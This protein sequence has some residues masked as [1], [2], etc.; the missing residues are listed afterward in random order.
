MLRSR[1]VENPSGGHSRGRV[2]AILGMASTTRGLNCGILCSVV[3]AAFSPNFFYGMF[4]TMVL[5]SITSELDFPSASVSG[6]STALLL[7][8]LARPGF[9]WVQRILTDPHSTG[10]QL[11]SPLG[12]KNLRLYRRTSLFVLRGNDLRNNSQLTE[13]RNSTLEGLLRGAAG[14]PKPSQPNPVS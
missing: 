5:A 7:L 6:F 8:K 2:A 14:S 13:Q 4:L 10:S 12:N 3:A 9:C 11:Q 1:R